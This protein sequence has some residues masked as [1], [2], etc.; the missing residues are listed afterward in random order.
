MFPHLL[1][2]LILD[3]ALVLL[4]LVAHELG[5]FLVA[6]FYRVPVKKLGFHWMGVYVQRVRTRGWPEV[7]I[8]LAGAAMNLML[9]VAFWDVNHWFALCNLTI[10]WVNLLPITHSDGSHALDALRAMYPRASI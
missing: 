3:C 7:S 9:A 2:T 6:R 1:F 10:G 5:H 4:C 8:C